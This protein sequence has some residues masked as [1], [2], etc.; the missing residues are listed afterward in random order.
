MVGCR[1]LGGI[2]TGR[3]CIIVWTIGLQSTEGVVKTF[4]FQLARLPFDDL[5]TSH[6]AA[7][8]GGTNQPAQKARATVG[9]SLQFR[10]AERPS[11]VR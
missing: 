9:R 11:V 7:I 6:C 8:D 4:S 5:W 3:L 10:I 2:T 1:D